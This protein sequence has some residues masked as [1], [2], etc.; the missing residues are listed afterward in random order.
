MTDLFQD[1]AR[2]LPGYEA[3]KKNWG[4]TVA[5]GALLAIAGGFALSTVVMATAA[6][7]FF[8]G[9]AMIVGGFAEVFHGFAMRT[10]RHFFWMLVMGGFYILAG[11]LV[12][13]NP[14]LAASFITLMIGASLLA[15]GIVRTYIAVQLP[16]GGAK[17]FLVFSAIL[18][19]VVGALIIAQWPS[20]SLWVIGVFLGVDLFFAGMGWVGVGLTMRNAP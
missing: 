17:G 3:L 13:R 10:W 20:S 9:F 1:Y 6:T 4:W 19:L 8:V 2:A 7:V 15:S 5:F 18:T 16:S 12:V 11:A 14:L